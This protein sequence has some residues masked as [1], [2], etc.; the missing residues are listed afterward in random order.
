M[1][2]GFVNVAVRKPLEKKV[3][4]G[5]AAVYLRVSGYGPSA[6]S[7]QA[8]FDIGLNE[9]EAPA[10]L[11]QYNEKSGKLRFKPD[12][13]GVPLRDLVFTIPANIAEAVRGRTTLF[14]MRSV[15]FT[16]KQQNGWFYLGDV[17]ARKPSV[18]YIQHY[19]I[20]KKEDIDATEKVS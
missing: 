7:R 13:D 17:S 1:P 5:R 6:L 20:K 19:R 9:M 3:R 14:K 10:L 18:T 2:K 15:Y 12:V 16:L 11:F 4:G 8:Y